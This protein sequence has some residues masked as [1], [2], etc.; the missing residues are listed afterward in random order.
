MLGGRGYLLCLDDVGYVDDDAQLDQFLER[1]RAE[2]RAGQLSMLL[3]SR[4]V[5][6]FVETDDIKAL[7]G[8]NTKDAHQLLA[9]RNIALDDQLF[10]ELHGQTGGNAQ[11]L[12]LAASALQRAGDP[13]RLIRDL[14][15][16]DDIERYLLKEVD[17][18]LG[19]DERQVLQ[20]VAVL[21][22]DGGTRDAIEALLDG[23]NIRRTLRA[24]SDRYLLLAADGPAGREYRLHRMVQ[25]F[26]YGELGKRERV[27]LHQ[28]A[29]AYYE[30]EERD[31][32]RAAAHF[33]RAGEYVRAAGLAL[34][35]A[36]S[37]ISQ[38]RV[39]ELRQLLERFVVRQIEPPA[40]NHLD[41]ERWAAV[42][43]ALAQTYFY[44]GE[45]KLARH[46]YEEAF[47]YL[48][49]LPDSPIV[50]NFKASVC[51]GMGELLQHESPRLALEWLQRGLAILGAR[52]R[53]E[54]TADLYIRIGNILSRMSDYPAAL[55]AVQH[56]LQ[57]LPAGNSYSRVG[58]LINLGHIAYY[59][60][61]LDKALAYTQQALDLNQQLHD[62]F[63]KITIL[64]NL[65]A[66]KAI[67]GDWGAAV[68]DYRQAAE[69]AEQLGN[70]AER[71]RL[72]TNLGLLSINRGDDQAA[73][74]HLI[75]GLALARAYNLREWELTGQFGLAELH[76]RRHETHAAIPLLEEVERL[77]RE[78][79]NKS[80]IQEVYR[81]WSQVNIHH[82]IQ[83]AL[84]NADRALSLAND[85]GDSYA[86]GLSLQTQ[87]QALR[88][89]GQ[90][91]AAITAFTRSLELLADDP[92]ET[93][94]TQMQFGL[95][96]GECGD[97]ER[98]TAMLQEARA[99]FL[100]L[101]AK[102]DLA[103][104]DTILASRSTV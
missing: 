60:T 44:S 79:E 62:A 17:A 47:A 51:T 6:A 39:R 29:G 53:S 19:A 1:L 22:D 71:T 9:A 38:G 99:T 25:P 73:S 82:D 69:L 102:R 11:F 5:P 80:R 54:Q 104:V 40:A 3:I 70:V 95:V 63:R 78:T 24:L 92:Y 41:P 90:A 96:L 7:A 57:L 68:A 14:V 74:A 4:R 28:L 97:R 76:I 12:T 46:T 16:A 21:L 86:E 58:A 83:A 101:G 43:V 77:A 15:A 93:A 20:I 49:G 103:E 23:A 66:F 13:A 91:E 42:L 48:D 34:A 36:R 8:L 55:H 35:D 37:L 56:G 64:G 26:Y 87:G 10:A 27:R 67:A 81:Y 100:R 45:L 85:L 52:G 31:L 59:Q 89:A 33:D 50:I 61:N 75:N 30:T 2:L 72:E 98:G 32:L 84:D 88:I 18:K 94:R 65:G